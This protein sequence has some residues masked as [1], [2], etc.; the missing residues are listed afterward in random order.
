M[1]ERERRLQAQLEA[2]TAALS[3]TQMQLQAL[4]ARMQQG[5][6][7]QPQQYQQPQFEQEQ[8]YEDSPAP[9][10]D[11]N[12]LILQA[13][14]QKAAQDATAAVE[15]RRGQMDAYQDNVKTRMERLMQDYPALADESSVLVSR[16]RQVY[17]RV[18]RENPGLDNATKY[19]LA[20][21]EAAS[22]LGA[23][24]VTLPAEDAGWTMG[25]GGQN[26][27]LPTKTG[28]SRLTGPIIKN[29]QAYGINIDPKTKEGQ[30]NLRELS[31]YTARFNADRNEEH[32][33]YR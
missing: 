8:V 14:T 1:T 20:V 17:D 11:P 2:N 4:N 29:A 24:P 9:Q 22:T 21:R 32:L 33:K 5:Y 16:A 3:R 13:I 10:P 23:R 6:Q 26:P 25:D 31:E 7:Q 12:A 15:W 18:Q 30:A 28:K 27:A 19:E